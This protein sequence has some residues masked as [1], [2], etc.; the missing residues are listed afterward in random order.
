MMMNDPLITEQFEQST[1]YSLLTG[2]LINDAVPVIN[3]P[4]IS[5]VVFLA[6]IIMGIVNSAIIIYMFLSRAS[7]RTPSNIFIVNLAIADGSYLISVLVK[8][9]SMIFYDGRL[10]YGNSVCHVFAIIIIITEGTSLLAMSLIA[11]SRYVAIIH[12]QKK[13]IMTWRR[14]VALCT[15]PWI[16]ITILMIPSLTGWGRIRWHPASWTCTFAW[17]YNAWYN[18]LVFLNSQGVSSA[19]MLFCYSQ[20]YFVYRKSKKRVAGVNSAQNG[21]KKNEIRLA[22]QLM[23]IYV[24]YNI[25]WLPYFIINIFLFPYGDGP[26]W[27][28][29]FCVTCVAM[30]SAVNI[31]VYLV[32]NHTFRRECF[33]AIGMK[34]DAQGS[35]S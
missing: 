13:H 17:S 2:W 30:N 1:L 27:L 32:C 35:S 26:P 34:P 9:T 24:I 33:L 25:C 11:I 6:V 28:Y 18:F 20:I 16:H 12:P 14:C 5:S 3:P 29:A 21:P 31:Y 4:M 7:L 19:I 8:P 22:V 10:F 23:V 15:W